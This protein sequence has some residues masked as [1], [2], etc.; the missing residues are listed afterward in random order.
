MSLSRHLIAS[1]AFALFA[2]AQTAA[3]AVVYDNGTPT[4]DNG[5]GIRASSAT[6]DD[7]NIAAGATIGSVTFYFQ[8]YNGITGWDQQVDYRIRSDAGDSLGAVLAS[9]A[10]QNLTATESSYA[11]CCGGGNAWEVNFD[12]VSD[13]VA[14][15]GTTYWLELTGAG[16]SAGSAWWVTASAAGAGNGF[17]DGNRNGYEFAF[18]L[19]GSD[20]GGTVPEPTGL[21]LV[22]LALAGLQLTRRRRA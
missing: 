20:G 17:T 5:W 19:S 14:A 7:F 18:S 21:A 1:A 10:A 13:F 11:W 2:V 12:L 6:A 3:A 4:T 22:G 16:G 8:N 9:G 15:A